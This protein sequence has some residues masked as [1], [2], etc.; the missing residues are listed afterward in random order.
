ME[1]ITVGYGHF[2]LTEMDQ[3]MSL[4]H[5]LSMTHIISSILMTFSS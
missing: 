1:N 3:A 4:P 5:I 2:Y